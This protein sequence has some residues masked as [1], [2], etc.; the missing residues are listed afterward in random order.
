ML[1][2]S[3]RLNEKVLFPTL[4]TAVQVVS[5]KGGSV[6]LGIEAPPEVTILRAE[7]QDRAAERKRCWTIHRVENGPRRSHVAS[8]DNRC[9]PMPSEADWF[10]R[11]HDD[12]SDA[13]DV[14]AG[15]GRITG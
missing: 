7:L 11:D 8:P 14:T 2:L 13:N 5:I 1:V 15:G 9:D 12:G 3:R 4:N 10:G 6:R